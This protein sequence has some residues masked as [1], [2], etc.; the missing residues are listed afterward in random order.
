MKVPE[1]DF[2][3]GVFFTQEV[4]QRIAEREGVQLQSAHA[5]RSK[6]TLDIVELDLS[7]QAVVE[8]FGPFVKYRTTLSSEP[9][10]SCV[11]ASHNAFALLM[12]SAR[13]MATPGLPS[14]RVERT[15]KDRLYNN[16]LKFLEVR[17]LKFSS[18]AKASG[19]KLVQSLTDTLWYIDGHHHL[20]S[21]RSTAPVPSV[22]EQF[23]S[24]NKPEQS[25]H[26]K[27][28]QINLSSVTLEHHARTLA[29]CLQAMY[30]DAP[31]WKQ[32]KTEVA[33]LAES[34]AG[35]VT[36][37]AKKRKVVAENQSSETPVRSLSE[38]TQLSYLP[39]AGTIPS[40]LSHRHSLPFPQLLS[41]RKSMSMCL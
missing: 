18:D 5:G 9:S 30:W 41:I 15:A 11:V 12:S 32:F 36:Y 26:R 8:S 16:I 13:S 7:V 39:L 20:L 22:F 31:S 33:Q 2:T 37:L 19:E 17:N 14:R 25:K 23:Q 29:T 28:S 6:E 10:S 27:R 4:L 24:Y 21:E 40:S 3:F 38:N 35:Y 1:P 34:L